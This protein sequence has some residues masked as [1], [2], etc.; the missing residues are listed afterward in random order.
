MVKAQ[1]DSLVAP[2]LP[3]NRVGKYGYVRKQKDERKEEKDLRNGKVQYGLTTS[4]KWEQKLT[5][6][7]VAKNKGE[8]SS[9]MDNV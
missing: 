8:R 2:D 6:I 9:A 4:G 1:R 7:H 5:K 3:T